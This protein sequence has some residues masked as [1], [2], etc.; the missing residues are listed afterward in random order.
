VD[1]TFFTNE[2]WFCLSISDNS[3]KSCVGSVTNPHEIKDLP[4]RD[5]K[6]GVWCVV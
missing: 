1:V 2:V 3:Q 6:V 5:Q 4:L